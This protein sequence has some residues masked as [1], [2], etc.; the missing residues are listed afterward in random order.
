MLFHENILRNFRRFLYL[1][2]IN[3]EIELD[4]SWSKNGIISEISITPRIPGNPYA[5]PP[6]Q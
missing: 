1:P 3:C 2:L 5:N 4:L 6:V